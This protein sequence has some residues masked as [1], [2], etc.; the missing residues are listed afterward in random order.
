MTMSREPDGGST[1]RSPDDEAQLADRDDGVPV[2]SPNPQD[3]ILDII[4]TSADFTDVPIGDADKRAR[5][6]NDS[7]TVIGRKVKYSKPS[8][9]QLVLI[10]AGEA[11]LQIVDWWR[12]RPIEDVELT[13]VTAFDRAAS[14]RMLPGALAGLY[15]P[16]EI[17]IDVPRLC[18]E[19]GVR[20]IV[21]R[22]NSIDA[23]KRQI[24]FAHQ[25][26]L[27]F[28]LASI[29]IG[30][31]PTEEALWQ[32]HRIM[33]ST[34]P[35]STFLARF[36][37]RFH[38]L[39]EQ[40]KQAPGEETL[41]VAVVGS[42]VD[43][44]ELA[45]SLEQRRFDLE[46]PI[47]VRIVDSHSEILPGMPPSTIR[48]VKKLFRKR[49]IEMNL[50]SK[51][52]DCD[53]LGPSTLILENGQRLRA[54]LVIWVAEAAPPMAVQGFQ[55]PKTSQGFLRHRATLQSAAEVPVFVVG[56]VASLG[57][58]TAP[59]TGIDAVRQ[60]SVLQTNLERWFNGEPFDVYRPQQPSVPII[61]CA[62]GS[63]ILSWK[64]L[65]IHANWV[66]KL[67]DRFDRQWV[68]RFRP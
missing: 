28:D 63:A 68:D 66:W 33:I 12:Q 45:F 47:D 42:G 40:W 35:M 20:L 26:A 4:L 46:L 18:D 64:G 5:K 8:P 38:E 53:D 50:G 13:L 65:C 43:S 51:V 21:D 24:E 59:K 39:V 36:S 1:E 48:K 25:P 22:V 61:S 56:D 49:G 16:D 62:D 52:V 34:K 44:V 31:V 17:L 27:N 55:L 37:T 29:N 67:R 6:V 41:Q 3:S 7:R 54:D 19:R 58:V 14:S 11:H 9:K 60:A 30:S 2:A 15:E 10:G 32:S 57:E 23:V